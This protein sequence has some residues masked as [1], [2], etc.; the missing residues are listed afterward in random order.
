M[1]I[2]IDGR[3][4]S[5][6]AGQTVLDAARAAD[7]SIPTI[8]YL[9]GLPAR[10]ACRLCLVRVNGGGALVP[11]CSTPATEGSDVTTSD[12]EIEQ[13]RRVVLSLLLAEHGHCDERACELRA[14]A[15][16]LGVSPPAAR[17][18]HGGVAR[19]TPSSRD[20][21]GKAM[22]SDLITVNLERCTSCGRCV[23]A[24]LDRRVIE[25]AGR[26]AH[27]TFSF[28]AQ[29]SLAASE[30]SGCGDCVAVCPVHALVAS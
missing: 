11:A 23:Q 4:V 6:R 20:L 18:S 3:P 14:M 27:L 12:P 29:R 7:V 30:C 5:I 2:S 21:A 19:S 9:H 24:C 25:H 13:V 15:R 16:R 26:G 22:G 10:A 1:T 17:E 8:C 28:S